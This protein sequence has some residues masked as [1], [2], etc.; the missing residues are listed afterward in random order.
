VMRAADIA[1]TTILR[2]WIHW[3]MAR[4][5][6]PRTPILDVAVQSFEASM[7]HIEWNYG[8]PECNPELAV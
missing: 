5:Q 7:G 4:I 6:A 3:P 1:R 2:R 8:R